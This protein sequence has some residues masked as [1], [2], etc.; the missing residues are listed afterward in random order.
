MG[1]PK[2]TALRSRLALAATV[3]LACLG[4]VLGA[5]LVLSGPGPAGVASA[6]PAVRSLEAAA[7]PTPAHAHSRQTGVPGMG[8]RELRAF[9]TATLGDEHAAEHAEIRREL[10][11]HPPK[12]DPGGVERAQQAATAAAAEVGTPAE[13]GRWDFDATKTLPIVAIHS[14]LLPTGK[15]MFFSYPQSPEWVNSAE[16]YLWD[17]ASGAITRKDPP[18]EVDP[19]DG[20]LKPANIWCAGPYLHRRR[21]ARGVRRQPRLRERPHQL[22]GPG[23]GLHV[24][25]LHRDSG[26]G[27]RTWRTA[28]GTR[29]ACG[30]PTAA[31]RSPAASTRPAR[32]RWTR[33]WRPSPHPPRAAGRARSA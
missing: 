13:I 10:R 6:G 5:S 1:N 7:R 9:E 8:E 23:Q 27:S 31:S 19:K 12:P 32:T 25:P 4:A 3:A 30:W 2:R 24:Q 14:A 15:V 33:T 21:R 26:T 17:P 22:E 16:A 18:M 28:A 29:P 20:Q 11:L